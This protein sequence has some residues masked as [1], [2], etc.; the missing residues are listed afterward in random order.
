[1]LV[2]PC[3]TED[4]HF[5]TDMVWRCNSDSLHLQYANTKLIFLPSE[6]ISQ[7][8]HVQRHLCRWFV[9]SLNVYHHDLCYFCCCYAF[10]TPVLFELPFIGVCSLRTN[11]TCFWWVNC[12]ESIETIFYRRQHEIKDCYGSEHCDI[13]TAAFSRNGKLYCKLLASPY[14]M[15]TGVRVG[16]SIANMCLKRYQTGLSLCY[17]A[18]FSLVKNALCCCCS[19]LK[20]TCNN[21][22]EHQY[23]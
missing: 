13:T 20:I 2:F 22:S 5:D 21:V 14:S 4:W 12:L 10:W 19:F 23:T 1:M 8:R 15:C 18:Q 16:I 9:V 7:S 11:L 17:G 3:Y 6:G